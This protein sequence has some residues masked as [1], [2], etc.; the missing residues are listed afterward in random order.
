MINSVVVGDG[1]EQRRERRSSRDELIGSGVN[2]ISHFKNL[3]N[4]SVV[5]IFI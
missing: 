2:L 4:V 3:V 5:N 1:K